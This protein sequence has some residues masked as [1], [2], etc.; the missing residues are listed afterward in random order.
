MEYI[1]LLSTIIC[2]YKLS[3][4]FE[5]SF[6]SYNLKLHFL[7]L[8]YNFLLNKKQCNLQSIILR[9]LVLSSFHLEAFV[10]HTLTL[11]KYKY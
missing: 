7:N 11:L 1:I 6:L 4:A 8:N 5:K 9:H 10:V 3:I 2:Y